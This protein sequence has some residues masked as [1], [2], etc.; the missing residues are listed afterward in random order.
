MQELEFKSIIKDKYQLIELFQKATQL[1]FEKKYGNL[2]QVNFYLKN[3]LKGSELFSKLCEKCFVEDYLPDIYI[4]QLDLFLTKANNLNLTLRIRCNDFKDTGI[5][6][7]LL[8]IKASKGDVINGEDR[9]ELEVSITK[10]FVDKMLSEFD[11]NSVWNRMQFKYSKPPYSLD[12]SFNAG[13][14]WIAE[15]E[16]CKETINSTDESLLDQLRE[17]F[18]LKKLNKNIL[19]AMYKI[20]LKNNTFYLNEYQDYNFCSSVTFEMP[21]VFDHMHTMFELL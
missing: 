9:A 14:G 19:N 18:N 17:E 21:T 13:Y 16:V 8:I 11:T 2:H 10:D 7:N 5:T 12:V 1:N 6:N 4:N 3:T 20:Y 15:L